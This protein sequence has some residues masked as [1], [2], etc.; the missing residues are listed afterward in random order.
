MVDART[1]KILCL[2]LEIQTSLYN[3]MK[4]MK[5]NVKIEHFFKI[6]TSYKT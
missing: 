1:P 2:I 6:N 5:N 3:S 4:E